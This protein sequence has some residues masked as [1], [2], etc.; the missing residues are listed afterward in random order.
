MIWKCS[1]C[2]YTLKADVPPQKCPSCKEGCT[3]V[4]ATCYTPECGG[5]EN[6]NPDMY[7]KKEVA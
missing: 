7:R 1:D 2:G 4:D 6:I 3:F 5:P